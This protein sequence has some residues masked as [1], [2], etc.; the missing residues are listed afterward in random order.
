MDFLLVMPN[1]ADLHLKSDVLARFG[2]PD[3]PYPLPSADLESVLS[4]GGELP[5]AMMLHG[6]QLSGREG[7]AEWKKY[8]QAMTRLAELLAPDDGRDVI[9]AAGDHWWVEIGPLDLNGKLVTVQR[10]DELIAA[11]TPRHDGRLRVSVF[12]PLDAKSAEYLTGLGQL[13]HPEHGVCMRENNWEYALD[14]SAGNG[15]YYASERGEAYLSYWEKGLGI[16]WDGTEI[17]E[18]RQQTNLVPR[19]AAHVI[20]ELGVAHSLSEDVESES[21]ATTEDDESESVPNLCV[22]RRIWTLIPAQTGQ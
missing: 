2:L 14:C 5:L 20:V 22:F 9:S 19:P 16:S 13:P 21:D 3:I 11:I 4:G 12:R 7:G 10:G 18:W 17:P 6:L 8:E 1:F 15:N